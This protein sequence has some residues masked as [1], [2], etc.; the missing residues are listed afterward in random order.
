[1]GL[2]FVGYVFTSFGTDPSGRYFLPFYIPLAVIA[3]TSIIRFPRI[4]W[5]LALL[6][7]VLCYNIFGT[8]S[9]AAKFPYLT[10]QFYEPAQVDHSSMGEL[11]SFLSDQGETVGYSNYWVA[12][13]LAFYTDE[14]IIA[15]P[16]LPYHPDLTYTDRDNRLPQ[17]SRRFE[18]KERYFYITTKN[19]NLD[20]VL[21]TSLSAMDIEFD[22]IEIGDYH[23]FF[24][25]SQP[26][27]P[28]ALGLYEHYK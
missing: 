19:P 7:A 4:K 13:P 17:Y 25:L 10:T 24:K 1:M 26:I 3:G 15:L 22:Y 18:E 21:K 12:Y 16:F 8:L 27:S 20:D 23:V 14:R 2:V 6:L 11:I 28:E 5:I 9:S